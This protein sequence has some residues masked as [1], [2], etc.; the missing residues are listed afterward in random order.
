MKSYFLQIESKAQYQETKVI[1]PCAATKGN[2]EKA[3]E[4]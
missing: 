4:P 2:H 3:G 1:R